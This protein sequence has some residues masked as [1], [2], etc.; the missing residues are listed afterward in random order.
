MLHFKQLLGTATAAKAR[1]G[2]LDPSL[3][4]RHLLMHKRGRL[5]NGF[6]PAPGET[7]EA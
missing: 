4:W 1:A 5:L 2:P 3:G 6:Q 7:L